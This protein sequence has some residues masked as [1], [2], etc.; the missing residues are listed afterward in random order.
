MRTFIPVIL[1]LV[2]T[3]AQG[4][5]VQPI[6][7]SG[8]NVRDDKE[9]SL[10]HFDKEAGVVVILVGYECPFDEYYK[11]RI[12]ELI[13]AYSEKVPFL[14]VNPYLEPGESIEKMKMHAVASGYTVPYI[15]DKEQ[16]IM[17]ALGA[18]KTPEA[19]LLRKTDQGFVILYSGAIDDNPQ[20]P[21]G[22]KQHYLREAIEGLL[23]G[24]A[25]V[26]SVRATGCTVRK[27]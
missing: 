4:Q 27:R 20:L 21:S 25:S 13:G 5:P 2:V 23:T 9:V 18:R 12:R 1:L 14:L 16:K 10:T 15:A 7:F 11:L 26:T 22:A 8:I 3:L 19:Y 17:N 24:N 6:A